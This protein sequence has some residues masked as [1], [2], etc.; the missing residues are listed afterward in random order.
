MGLSPC[1]V[2]CDRAREVTLVCAGSFK[3]VAGDCQCYLIV[4]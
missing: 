4:L 2:K 3:R 1:R